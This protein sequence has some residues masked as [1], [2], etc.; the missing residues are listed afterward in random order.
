MI[1]KFQNTLTGLKMTLYNTS[2]GQ[3]ELY[4]APDGWEKAGYTFSRSGKYSGIFRKNAI[5]KLGF[6][7]EGK[8]FIEKVVSEQG[9]EAEI[10]LTIYQWD[11]INITYYEVFRGIVDILSKD[12][13][14]LKYTV[15]IS[16]SSFENKVIN[17]DS[18]PVIVTKKTPEENYKSLDGKTIIGFANEGNLIT[19][20]SRIDFFNSTFES[21]KSQSY[22]S[23]V[24]ETIF[25]PVIPVLNLTNTDFTDQNTPVKTNDNSFKD[26]Q[27]AFYVNSTGVSV[28]I[29]VSGSINGTISIFQLDPLDVTLKLYVIN[30]TS[31]T[32]V[33]EINIPLIKTY[34]GAFSDLGVIFG[35]YS[36]S[37]DINISEI[38][39]T[40]NYIQFGIFNALTSG[41]LNKIARINQG[42]I[43]DFSFRTQSDFVPSKNIQ[44]MMVHEL[45]SRIGQKIT[46]GNNPF[47][48]DLFGRKDSE[49]RKYPYTQEAGLLAFTNGGLI[50]DFSMTKSTGIDEPISPL[51]V[52]LGDSFDAI[53]SIRP[54]GMGIETIDGEKV[55]R[56][57]ELPYFYDKRVSIL[58]DN[59]TNIKTD[60][61]KDL[62]H[63]EAEIGFSKSETDEK[64]DGMYDYNTKSTWTNAIESDKKKENLVTKY[65]AS[66]TSINEARKITKKDNPTTD[67]KY[68]SI[69]YLIEV[70]D[71]IGG[72][73]VANGDAEQGLSDWNITS[74]VITKNILGSNRFVIPQNNTENE[75]IYQ[76]LQVVDEPVMSFSY[77]L[78]SENELTLTPRFQITARLNDGSFKSLNQYGDWVD[79]QLDFPVTPIKGVKE[80]NLQSFNKFEISAKEKLNNIERITIAFDTTFLNNQLGVNKYVIDD[81]YLSG[82]A[83]LKARTTEGF[84]SI[85][86][87]VNANDSY[88]INLSPARSRN[89]HGF[90]LRAALDGKLNTSLV[91]ANS[92]K[93]STLVSKKTN[94]DKPVAESSDILINEL[95]KPLWQIERDSFDTVLTAQQRIELN[96]N[97]GDG[98]PKKLALVGYRENTNEPYSYGWIDEF[99]SGKFNEKSNFEI[100]KISKYV[101]IVEPAF[102]IDD[103]GANFIDN[104]GA[105]FII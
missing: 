67:S 51:S 56:I 18:L 82:S 92:D 22:E 14:R 37:A 34:L 66:N 77:A 23:Q 54:I 15:A 74:G 29:D 27:G 52:S 105:K 2:E 4:H 86:G 61:N 104:D 31:D 20:P 33:R 46:S 80:Q 102:A 1:D 16:D 93:I 81:I 89:R 85:T 32:I 38:I 90:R 9:F 84:S 49:P 13:D 39:E 28:E 21:D 101:Q 25:N 53:N 48:S 17:R 68:D 63:N 73:A 58:I 71:N 72:N 87:I 42:L 26:I 60:Y 97:F 36:I 40:G 45:F 30:S 95:D 47:Y 88:N 76:I 11:S 94:E 43:L 64:R 6:V 75:Y 99:K 41:L 100:R 12:V 10:I 62:I 7:K 55:I 59:A 78:I 24:I 19:L 5:D 91:F 35:I 8:A 3:L 83:R 50:R 44:S 79:G 70:V 65:S 57:E 103:D 96:S 69:N 98:K